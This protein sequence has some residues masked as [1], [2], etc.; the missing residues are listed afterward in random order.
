MAAIKLVKGRNTLV[1]RH[2]TQDT[3]AELEAQQ[4]ASVETR[5]IRGGGTEDAA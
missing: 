2:L 4:K 3:L 5:H 1:F